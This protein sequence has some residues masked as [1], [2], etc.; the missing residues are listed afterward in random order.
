MI[1]RLSKTPVVALA[2]CVVVSV[3]LSCGAGAGGNLPNPEL[4][5]SLSTLDGRQLGPGDYL[6]SVLLVEFWATW[7]TPC[8]AQARILE[9]LHRESGEGDEVAFLAVSL[10]ESEEIVR[11][12]LHKSPFPYPVLLDPGDTL[13]PRLGIYAL[14]TVMIVDRKGHIAYFRI[15]IS[16]GD[17]LREVLAGLESGTSQEGSKQAAG[18]RPD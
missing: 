9:S 14:P 13:S 2:A 17:D 12:Y 16:S 7:C 15:G 3:V 1:R 18:S 4:D 6:G 10:G 11:E 5:F 8:R